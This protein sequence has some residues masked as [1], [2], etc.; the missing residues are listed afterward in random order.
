MAAIP[1]AIL[2]FLSKI[3]IQIV[4]TMETTLYEI[5]TDILTFCIKVEDIPA[6]IN[7]AFEKLGELLKGFDGREVYGITGCEEGTLTYRA[8][9][10]E[11]RPGEARQF[12]L[13]YYHIPKG[14]Y[15]CTI[16][17]NWRQHLPEVNPI[18]HELMQHPEAAKGAICLEYYKDDDEALLM[19]NC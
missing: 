3:W 5:E 17:K 8:C 16:L 18:F 4:C 2:P 14:K 11:L 9:V 1:L 12:N 6:G 7:A 13:P 10:T 15:I 19:V